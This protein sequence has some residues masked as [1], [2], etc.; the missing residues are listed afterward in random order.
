MILYDNFQELIL[1]IF[2][3]GIEDR[4]D[5]KN[6]FLISLFASRQSNETV[7]CSKVDL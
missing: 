4:I 1:K 6:D 3:I 7:I 5:K 2:L